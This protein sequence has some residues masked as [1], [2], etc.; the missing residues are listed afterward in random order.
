MICNHLRKRGMGDK[1][2]LGFPSDKLICHFGRRLTSTVPLSVWIS[3][4]QKNG[5][6]FFKNREKIVFILLRTK[7]S[8]HMRYIP[9]CY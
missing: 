4:S 7:S 8:V 6:D 5:K 2:K 9:K 3:D 1:I